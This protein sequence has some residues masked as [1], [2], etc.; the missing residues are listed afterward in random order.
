MDPCRT[1]NYERPEIAAY[2][3]LYPVLLDSLSRGASIADVDVPVVTSELNNVLE[4]C[5]HYALT[6][7]KTIEDSLAWADVQFNDVISEAGL[8]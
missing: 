5:C 4:L 1:S 7:E 6:G 8:K 3:P 2:N